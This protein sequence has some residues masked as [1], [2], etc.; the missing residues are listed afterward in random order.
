MLDREVDTT[1]VRRVVELKRFALFD[2][3]DLGELATLAQNVVETEIAP[4]ERVAA[5]GDRLTAIDF[6]LDGTIATP[7][8]EWHARDVF[9]A[10]EVFAGRPVLAEARATTRTRTLRL[11]AE[12]L[13][14]ILDDSFGVLVAAIR[15]LAG[16]A[17]AR[18]GQLSTPGFVPLSDGPIGLVDRLLLLRRQPAFARARVRALTMLAH[19]SDEMA[20]PD[21]TTIARAGEL[22]TG[23]YVIASGGVR[24]RGGAADGAILRPGD[25]FGLVETL[26]AHPLAMTLEAVDR[27]RAL[28]SSSAALLDV[29]E[30]HTDLGLALLATLAHQLMDHALAWPNTRTLT[31]STTTR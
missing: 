4:G 1:I 2:E 31:S 29:L 10:L 21:G 22:A 30:D 3:V 16:A 28:A 5:A 27:V 19:V 23:A 14:E 8:S 12:D 7:V 11:H 24:A 20:W 15:A 13:F 26:A 18:S 6:V 25:T 17:L 9:G